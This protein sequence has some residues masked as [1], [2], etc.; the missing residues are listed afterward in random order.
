MAE[1]LFFRDDELQMRAPLKHARAVLGRAAE[2]DFVL[3]DRSISRLQCEL[4]QRGAGWALVDLSGRGTPVSSR[5]ASGAG[6]ALRDGD[7]IR[8]GPFT[9]VFAATRTLAE[10]E[11]TNP[12]RARRGTTG[13]LDPS[14]VSLG[15]RARLRVRQPEGETNVVLQPQEGWTAVIGTDPDGPVQV[16]LSDKF[17]SAEHCR[18]A[19]RKGRWV[20]SDLDA[21]NGTFV[22]GVR[23]LE[24][25]LLGR[26]S[27]RVGETTLHFEEESTLRPLGEELLPGLVT[28]DPAMA[29]VV[30]RVRQF[31]P[32]KVPVYVRG[33]TGVGKEVVSRAVH[34]LSGRRDGPFV[35]LNC[36]AIAKE[37]V[38]S[39]L[40]GH[41]KGAFTGADRARAGAFEEA[42][43]GTLFLDEIGD[44][45]LA[46]QVKLLRVLER[47]EVRRLGGSRTNLVDVRIVS[48]SHRN[49]D[50]MVEDGSFREDLYWRLCVATIEIPPLRQR[51]GDV[52]PLA[53]HFL[54]QLGPASPRVTLSPAARARLESHSWMGNARELR[55]VVQTALLQRRGPLITPEDLTLR[56]APRRSKAGS[57][58]RLNGLTM[59]EIE[60]EA[61][62]LALERHDGDRRAAMEELGIARSTFFRK[63]AEFGLD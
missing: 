11:L 17:V 56:P 18:L 63:L 39:E 7:E 28:R 41:E 1:L 59:D 31:A 6:T 25:V 53:E 37:T 21:R 8:A 5:T 32:G 62:R 50:L 61:Y 12:R 60:R 33:E 19:F 42:H 35:A 9:I 30:E 36:G 20:L 10:P 45:P 44:L 55:N 24:C 27:I 47:G 43:G 22:D 23:I 2:A 38:E 48:A 58:L 46:L 49:L 51:L 14:A 52:L 40:F 34:L 3:P 29:P 13:P 4:V 15:R 26:A 54:E 57:T 16:Q